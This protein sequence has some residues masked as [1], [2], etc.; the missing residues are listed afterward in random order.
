MA[1]VERQLR[2][3]RPRSMGCVR[4]AVLGRASRCIPIRPRPCLPLVLDSPTSASPGKHATDRSHLNGGGTE[5]QRFGSANIGTSIGTQQAER[6]WCNGIPCARWRRSVAPRGRSQT[7]KTPAAR[8]AA[9]RMWRCRCPART[10]RYQGTAKGH[11][12]PL[13]GQRRT[14]IVAASSSA[15]E[16]VIGCGGA[17]PTRP[18]LDPSG[19]LTDR[20]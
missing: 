15:V 14:I 17:Q 2:R 19:H 16:V 13:P 6:R 3:M 10:A 11:H 20:I 12:R 7:E 9:A 4:R 1:P 8:S 18:T 5:E